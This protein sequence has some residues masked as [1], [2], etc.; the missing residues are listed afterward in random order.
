MDSLYVQ[1]NSVIQC[2]LT[3]S[4]PVE[5]KFVEF[6]DCEEADIIRSK[7][8]GAEAVRLQEE[9]LKAQKEIKT[10]ELK[11]KNAR[12]LLDQEKQERIY[13]EREKNDMAGQIGLV[14]DLLGKGQVNETREKLQQLQHSFTHIGPNHRRSTRD[15]SAIPLSTITENHD[16]LE[17]V[18]SISDIDITEDDLEESRTRSGRSFKRKSSPER[19]DDS[20]RK[21]RSRRSDEE[22]K[23]HE[24]KTQV[25]TYYSTGNDVKKFCTEIEVKPSATHV[26]SDDNA[27]SGLVS[28]RPPLPS[29]PHIPHSQQCAYSPR[30]LS[31]R[32]TPQSNNQGCVTPTHTPHTPI[33]RNFS[34]SKLNTRLHA[35][36]NKTIYKTEL[37]QPCGKR[38][39]FGK[40]ALK[41]R[42]CRATCHAECR[43]SVPLPCIPVATT[44]NTKGQQGTIADY[45]PHIPPMV[46][47]LVVHCCNEVENRGL[48]EVGIY[49]VSGSEKEVKELKEKFLRGKGLPNLSKFDIHA[50]C[51]TLKIFLRSLKEPLVTHLLWNDFVSAAERADEDASAAMYQAIS[52]LPQPNRDTLAWIVIHLQRVAECTEC[53]MPISN[54]AKMFGPTIVGYSVPEPQ[55]AVMVKET[56]HQ[57]LVMEKLLEISTDYWNTFINVT[58]EIMYD[59]FQSNNVLSG[60]ILG[61]L[62]T[63]NAKRRR[64]ILSRTPLQIRDTPKSRNQWRK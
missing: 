46:P 41:C 43:E 37:C 39:K 12:L 34:A 35:F 52:E 4:E 38:I 20:G 51:G 9:L 19:L 24:V 56:N 64:S 60:G 63:G 26:S 47:A 3:C 10:L 50:V 14:M 40:I 36:Q 31:A 6:L 23:I 17:S 2:L 48:S 29:T 18:L 25:T 61:D 59:N 8:L 49:R 1:Y 58:D 30:L 15:G 7:N 62:H 53:K 16:S 55:P 32:M 27:S 42:D 54:L 45:T 11:L 28:G 5:K 57:Q 44:P 22:K 21:R 33:M 13:V